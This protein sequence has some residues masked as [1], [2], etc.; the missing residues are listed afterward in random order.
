[1]KLL[2]FQSKIQA[3]KAAANLIAQQIKKKPNSIL[4]LAT[5][6]TMIPIYRELVK[7]KPDFSKIKTFN[8]DEY[9]NSQEYH[10]FMNKHLFNKVNIKS[11]NINFPINSS[12]DNQIKK[13]GGIDLS[14]LGLGRNAHIAFNEPGTKFSS[15][16]HITNLSEETRKVNK[17]KH[18]KAITM[19]ISTILKSK[20]ILLIATGSQKAKAIQQTLKGKITEDVPATALRKHKNAMMILDKE[21]SKLLHNKS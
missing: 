12:Y 9:Q 16:T 18:K 11:S 7:L 4:G 17:T 8:L 3:S 2:K 15:K 1:M 14:V 6:N 20:K 13:S 21:A 5:G 10:N 19:G